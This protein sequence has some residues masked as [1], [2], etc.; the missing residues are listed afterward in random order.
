MAGGRTDLP[1][2]ADPRHPARDRTRAHRPRPAAPPG[3]ADTAGTGRRWV[4]PG[5]AV[6]DRVHARGAVPSWRGQTA[7]VRIHAVVRVTVDID[8]EDEAAFRRAAADALAGRHGRAAPDDFDRAFTATPEGALSAVLGSPNQYEATAAWVRG[9]AGAR[10]TA[11]GCSPT[12]MHR[13]DDDDARRLRERRTA[14]GL[15]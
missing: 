14:L 13:G 10:L 6:A 9:F 7:A 8:D 2:A 12:D 1:A 11:L 5:K 15:D 4:S 3:T